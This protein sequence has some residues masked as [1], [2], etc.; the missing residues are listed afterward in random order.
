MTLQPSPMRL[1]EGSTVAV[2]LQWDTE[3]A[4]RCGSAGRCCVARVV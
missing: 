1:P 2:S 4:L 3:V